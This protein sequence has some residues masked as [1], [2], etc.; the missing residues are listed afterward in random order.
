MTTVPWSE[1]VPAQEITARARQ[2]RLSAVLVTVICGFFFAI[3][4]LAGHAWLTVALAGVSVRYGFRQAV[5]AKPPREPAAPE[6][7]GSK[8]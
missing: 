2:V 5:P 4:W 8:L 3:G 1:R 6:P 7:R